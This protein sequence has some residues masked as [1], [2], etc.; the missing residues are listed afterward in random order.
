MENGK[1][2]NLGIA[3]IIVGG[4]AFLGLF[5]QFTGGSSRIM[6]VGPGNQGIIV[7]GEGITS[8]QPDIARV[9]L[10]LEAEAP[11][12]K[13]AQRKNADQM[14]KI[15]AGLKALGLAEKD[16][17]TTDFNLFPNRQYD[18]ESG[19]E[20]LIGYRATNQVTVTVRDLKKLGQI[21]DGSIQ[22]GANTVNGVTF[23]VETPGK[24]REKTIAK[25]VAEARSKAEAMAKASGVRIRKINAINES[26]IDIRPYQTDYGYKRLEVLGAGA[27]MASNTP[28]EPGNVKI[29]ANVQ[30][31]FGI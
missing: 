10:G 21:I 7:N 8:V 24:W 23:S 1:K 22:N 3:V 30:I 13:E 12:A 11:T 26:S 4:M 28:L 5:M 17:Q 14:T 27:E 25:A 31:S 20:K 16:I 2:N 29:T 15:V 9:N 6:A 18:K 19:Q